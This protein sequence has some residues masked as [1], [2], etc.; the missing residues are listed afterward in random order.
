M[1][2]YP[3]YSSSFSRIRLSGPPKAGPLEKGRRA[4]AMCLPPAPPGVPTARVLGSCRQHSPREE[5]RDPAASLSHSR[6]KSHTERVSSV[7]NKS[8]GR[9]GLEVCQ[10]L[11][12]LCV[13]HREGRILNI[14]RSE[15]FPKTMSFF[16][17]AETP[18]A[19]SL[20]PTHSRCI[21]HRKQGPASGL[22]E[23]LRPGT[24]KG[25]DGGGDACLLPSP[26]TCAA[27]LVSK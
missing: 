3:F 22:R 24:P 10:A 18:S 1:L 26:V 21:E 12:Q 14:K 23:L 17:T 8:K 4:R 27:Y 20:V 5:E 25:G 16:S 9:G 6:N 11:S 7:Q 13:R 15:R 19:I 2:Q